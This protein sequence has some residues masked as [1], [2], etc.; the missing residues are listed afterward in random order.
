MKAAICGIGVVG[1]F[2]NGLPVVTP[3][4][5]RATI[6]AEYASCIEDALCENIEAFTTYL[7]VERSL[8]DPNRLE[9]LYPPDLANQ[10][11]IFDVLAQFRL[12]YATSA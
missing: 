3:R 7:T 10:L 8:T 5:A 2:G 9:V 4:L 12:Q 6:I 1:G 11:R